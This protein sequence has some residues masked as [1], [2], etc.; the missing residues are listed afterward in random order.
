MKRSDELKEFTEKIVNDN[1]KQH[2][3]EIRMKYGN[4]IVDSS[5]AKIKAMSKEQYA[6]VERLSEELNNALKAAFEEGNPKGELAQKACELHKEW[7][8]CF[9][10]NYSKEAHM[11]VA[12]IYV[13]DPRF[14]EYYDKIAPGCAAF[15]RDA[16]TVY[17]S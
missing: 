10:D 16:L 6:Q 14:T 4:E 11:G 2:G 8:C 7:L 1:E 5:N 13:N 3:E 12:Q 15:L 9:W 17:T